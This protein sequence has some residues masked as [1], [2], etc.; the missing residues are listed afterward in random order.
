[1]VIWRTHR[2]PTARN[3]DI[4]TELLETWP[5]DCHCVR[6]ADR[7]DAE[8]K[9]EAPWTIGPTEVP[10]AITAVHGSVNPWVGWPSGRGAVDWRGPR[11]RPPP[12]LCS[13]GDRTRSAS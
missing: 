12:R 3:V 7:A 10:T 1:M 6:S 5:D 4:Q 9:G 11:P 13:Q 2:E 8:N